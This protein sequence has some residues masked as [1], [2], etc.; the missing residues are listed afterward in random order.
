MSRQWKRLELEI[1]IMGSLKCKTQFSQV[2]HSRENQLILTPSPR[3]ARIPT[4]DV[5]RCALSQLIA[6]IEA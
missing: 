3:L 4:L 1:P 2:E 6:S 5:A